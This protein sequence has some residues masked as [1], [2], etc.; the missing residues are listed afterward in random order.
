M[1]KGYGSLS[2]ANIE[3][4]YIDS[5]IDYAKKTL[6]SLKKANKLL[7]NYFKLDKSIQ[8]IRAILVPT[9]V[10]Y[11]RLVT[12]LL[13]VN[14]EIPSNPGRLAQPQKK[15]IVFL[16]PSAYKS[17]S[18]YKYVPEEYERLTFH[19]LT[20]LFEEYLSPD[21]EVVPRW[22]SEG[23]AVNL[24][25][26]WKQY[27]QFGFRKPV[28]TAIRE[29]RIPTLEQIN[30][31]IPLAYDWGWTMVMCIEDKYGSEAIVCIV[32]KCAD[33]DILKF[34]NEQ[35]ETFEKSWRQWLRKQFRSA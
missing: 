24:S 6:M 2:E 11:E 15:D 1:L 22:W 8:S 10:E 20:H 28:E 27:D 4:R 33:D 13:G 34:L 19:E 23:M 26:Q 30:N 21:I 31:S 14:I 7:E 25:G 5:D 17:D 18:V 35:P 9:R 32:K 16:S 29:N 12:K 3:I